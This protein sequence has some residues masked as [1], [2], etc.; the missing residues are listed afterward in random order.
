MGEW[1]G[2][3]GREERDREGAIRVARGIGRGKSGGGKE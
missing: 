2:G 3:I 1:E